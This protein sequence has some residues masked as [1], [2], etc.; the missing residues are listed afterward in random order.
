MKVVYMYDLYHMHSISL[1]LYNGYKLNSYLTCFHQGF[2]AQL[3]EH[4][5]S[6]VEVMGLNPVGA[7]EFFLSFLYNC[8]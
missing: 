4:H 2:I 8:F 3:A 1:S 6:I 7:S 5:T